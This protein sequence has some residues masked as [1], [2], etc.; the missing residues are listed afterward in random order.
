MH[1]VSFFGKAGAVARKVHLML[2][3]SQLNDSVNSRD[4][5]VVEESVSGECKVRD[6]RVRTHHP[7]EHC[8]NQISAPR[9]PPSESLLSPRTGA[10]AVTGFS[11][12]NVA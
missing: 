2:L 9:S 11:I 12:A 3:T 10:R 8:K 7:L 4:E 5:H 1:Q 6:V